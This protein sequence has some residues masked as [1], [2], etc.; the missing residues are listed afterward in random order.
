MLQNCANEKGT[1][2]MSIILIPWQTKTK[3]KKQ[4]QINTPKQ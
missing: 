1:T 2:F 3:K 4:E